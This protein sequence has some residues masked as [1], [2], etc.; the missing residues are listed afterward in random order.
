VELTD[1]ESLKFVIPKPGADDA[2]TWEVFA[3]LERRGIKLRPRA[4]LT[5]L[6]ARLVLSDLFIHG[7]GGA[8]YDELTDAI[9]RRYYQFEPPHFI[10]ATATCKLPLQYPWVE[11]REL[12]VRAQALRDLQYHPERFVAHHALSEKKRELIANIPLPPAK[13]A[14]HDEIQRVNAKLTDLLAEIRAAKEAELQ[15]VRERYRWSRWLGS[16]EFAYC[17]FPGDM[18]REQLIPLAR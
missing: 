2:I 16:R 5:T 8:K 7:I 12:A 17:L 4:L 10:T 18:L 3:A 13:K 14:W 6:Y 15:L 9:V 1:R 11:Q